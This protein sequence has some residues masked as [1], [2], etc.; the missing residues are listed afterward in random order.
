MIW[1]SPMTGGFYD[2]RIHKTR[3]DDAVE[4]T[5]EYHRALLTAQSA[6]QRIVSGAG[7]RP[8]ARMQPPPSPAELAAAARATMRVSRFQARAALRGAGL[9]A[10]AEALIAA[11]GDD[12]MIEAWA[13]AVEIRRTSPMILAMGAALELSEEAIDDLFAAAARIEA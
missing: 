4:I 12:L 9:L 3:P 10:S 2:D 11:S 8:E 6:G 13:S 1:F 5:A 7:G